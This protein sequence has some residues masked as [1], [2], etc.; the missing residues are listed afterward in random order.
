MAGT[1]RSFL[2]LGASVLAAG[3]TGHAGLQARTERQAIEPPQPWFLARLPRLLE[4]SGTPGYAAVVLQRGRIVWEHYAGLVTAGEPAAVTRDTM[5]PAA[6]LGK[7]V[8]ATAA[9]SLVSAGT[10]DLDTPLHEY[11]SDHA[12]A[13]DRTRRITARHVLSHTSGLPNWRTTSQPLVSDFEPGARFSYSGEGYY[14][15]QAVIERLTGLGIQQVMSRALFEPVGMTS[16]TCT[17]RNDV[18]A[19]LVGGHARGVPRPNSAAELAAR[20][21]GD[22][23]ARGRSLDAYSGTDVREAMAR[24]PNAP[25]ALPILVIPNV[26]GSLL[27]TPRDYAAFVAAVLDPSGKA[28]TLSPAVRAEMTKPQIALNSQMGWGLGWGLETHVGAPPTLWHWGDNG[29]WKNFVLVEPA[30][31]SAVVVFTNSAQGMN[32]AERLITACTGVDHVAF[33]WL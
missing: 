27:T 17:W 32:V 15:L 21:L 14:F 6:S 11:L 23:A 2:S 5:W 10:L 3:A 24:I 16:S 7:P 12:A 25:P 18:A 28:L 19:R 20:L 9:L 30:D 8:F 31:N 1:R 22:A 4:V 13:D 26:A 33:Q 29:N